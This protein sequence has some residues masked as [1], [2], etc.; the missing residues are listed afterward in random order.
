MKYAREVMEL[1]GRHPRRWFPMREIVTYVITRVPDVQRDAARQGVL[2]VLDRLHECKSIA[3]R[4]PIRK[5]GSSPLYRWRSQK[6][7]M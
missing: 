2:R 5:S 4:R 6:R 1:M 7:D 3:I